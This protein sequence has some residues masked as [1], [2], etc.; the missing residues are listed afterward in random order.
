M[1]ALLGSVRYKSGDYIAFHRRIRKQITETATQKSRPQVR[2]TATLRE[3]VYTD[4]DDCVQD[5]DLA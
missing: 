1:D 5:D 3:I 4:Y 2:V